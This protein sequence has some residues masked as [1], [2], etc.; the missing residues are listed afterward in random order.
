[1]VRIYSLLYESVSS[2]GCNVICKQNCPPPK[3]KYKVEVMYNG[4]II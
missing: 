1:M 2:V 3:K 4:Y